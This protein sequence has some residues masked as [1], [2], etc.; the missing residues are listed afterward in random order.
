MKKFLLVLVLLSA[1]LSVSAANLSDLPYKNIKDKTGI[2]VSDN[3]QIWSTKFSKKNSSYYIKN[4]D[5]FCF[6]DGTLAFSINSPYMFLLDSR[7]I[8]YSN[9]DLKFYEYSLIDGQPE[10]R[11][12]SLDEVKIAFKKHKIIKISDFN[13]NTSSIKIKKKRG[14]L[15]L[16]VLNDTENT[17][18]DYKFSSGNAKFNTYPATGF[19]YVKKAGMIQLSKYAENSKDYPW[20]VLLVR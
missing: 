18:E 19:I 17:F 15:K 20:F 13:E 12:L 6:P 8:G 7:L 3:G 5:D 10:K 9:S 1:A 11:E 14:C 2:S 16:I 4:G